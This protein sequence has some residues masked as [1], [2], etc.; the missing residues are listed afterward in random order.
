M[1]G[2]IVAAAAGFLT[3]QFESTIGGPVVKAMRAYIPVEESE[4][5][6]V[7]FMVL[8]LCAGIVSVLLSSG[9]PFWVIAGGTLGYFGTRLFD[10]GKKAM[11]GKKDES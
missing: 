10:A 9:T 7:T 3:P 2:F 5:R 6:L 8:L 1:L 4:T 11:D